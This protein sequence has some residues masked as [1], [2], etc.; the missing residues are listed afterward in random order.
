MSIERNHVPGSHKSTH[1]AEASHGRGK[2]QGNSSP[3][4]SGG[5]SSLLLTLGSQDS[6]EDSAVQTGDW[7]ALA[8]PLIPLDPALLLAQSAP[9]Q[10]G[11]KVLD[12]KVTTST[13]SLKPADLPATDKVPAR[14]ALGA[15]KELRAAEPDPNSAVIPTLVSDLELAKDFDAA[16]KSELKEMAQA[17]HAA[18]KAMLADDQLKHSHGKLD[19]QAQEQKAHFSEREAAKADISLPQLMQ[20]AGT[21]ESGLKSSERLKER[22]ALKQIGA[23]EGGAWG[24]Q[25]LAEA[26][27]I[28]APADVGA[29]ASLSP[30][31]QVAE[32]VSYWIG[33]DVQNAELRF[34]GLGEGTVKVNI[35]MHGNEASVEFRSDQPETRQI[36]EGAVAHLK[37]LLGSEGLVLS[38]VSV[39][40]SGAGSADA[41]QARQVHAARGPARVA[42]VPALALEATV[43]TTRNTGRSIDLFV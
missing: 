3:G 29:S 20:I 16:L 30:E 8:D 11:A 7:V 15:Q 22:L 37:D 10:L 33:H 28:Q 24:Y 43:H 35:S 32:Q 27:R 17:A 38:S 6:A 4:D 31:M 9:L 18:H 23:S 21:N 25:A 40:N 26:G 39:G 13:D 1:G 41:R 2:P 34:D 12:L 5:F 14:D 36:L 19:L 42:N